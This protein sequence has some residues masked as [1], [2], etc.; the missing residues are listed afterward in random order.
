LDKGW[1]VRIA[2]LEDETHQAQLMQVWIEAAGH[3]CRAFNSGKQFIEALQRDTYDLLVL[4]WLLPDINGDEVLKWVREHLGWQLPV[5]FVTQKD[6]EADVVRGLELGA[7]DYMAK[8]V[9]PQE[10][11]AR[12]AALG[13]RSQVTVDDGVRAFGDF[14]VDIV[15][16]TVMREGVAIELTHK[17]FELALFLFRNIGRLL[18]RGHILECVWGQSAQLNTRTVDTHISRIRNKLDLNPEHG[19]RLSGVYHHGYRLERHDPAESQV[20]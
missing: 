6:S 9:K 4:D 18:S 12:I 3:D 2:L 1:K 7:D 11:L 5:I 16:H 8:P 14:S 20:S 10:M 19:W 15:T 13:R 17:E